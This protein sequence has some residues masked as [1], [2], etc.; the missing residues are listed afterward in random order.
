MA[1]KKRQPKV[2]RCTPNSQL[3]W[4]CA[5]ATDGELCPW[6]KDFTPV[7]DWTASPTKRLLYTRENEEEVW[8]DTYIITQ[9]PLYLNDDKSREGRPLILIAGQCASGKDYLAKKLAFNYG[10]KILKSNTTR[11][12]RDNE[13]NTHTFISTYQYAK[14][15]A[16]ENIVAET[17]VNGEVYYCTKQQIAEADIYVIDLKGIHDLENYKGRAIYKIL[18]TADD[19][20]RAIRLRK[21]IENECKAHYNADPALLAT[22]YRNR[23]NEDKFCYSNE[24]IAQIKWDCVIDNSNDN[25]TAYTT[26]KKFMY[27]LHLIHHWNFFTKWF[28]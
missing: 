16:D 8:E 2:P 14:D 7:K 18:I 28:K 4:S 6:V 27:K 25:N 24:R 15:K 21:R 5:K 12:K 11:K 1:R 20:T 23:Y 10:L 17:F 26:L 3:C 19:E 22:K 9:C 13:D